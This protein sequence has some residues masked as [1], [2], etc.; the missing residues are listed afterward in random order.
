MNKK[1]LPM[2]RWSVQIVFL[3]LLIFAVRLGV[4][5]YNKL[6]IFALIFLIGNY[7]CGWICP[8]GTVED[9]LALAGR[10]FIRHRIV[11]PQKFERWLRWLRYITL[12]VSLG[13]AAAL[14]DA[15]RQF[16][17]LAAGKTLAAAAL[18]CFAV[19]AVLSLFMDRPF[20]RYICPEGARYGAMSAARLFTITRNSSTCISCRSCDR[21][22]PMNIAVSASEQ[23]YTPQCISCGRCLCACPKEGTLK[24][25]LRNFRNP[26]AWLGTAVGIYFLVKAVLFAL[27]RF[28]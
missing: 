27:K 11:I 1:L 19:I 2:L 7:Y 4:P 25:R 6:L 18:A 14:L 22:C 5:L 13:A 20:C 10:R 15:R 21:V 12:F 16:F 23:L 17:T 24:V 28:G 3:L 8:F 26:L 9:L